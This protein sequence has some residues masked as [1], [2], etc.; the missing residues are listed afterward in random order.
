MLSRPTASFK[1]TERL[2]YC[3]GDAF[4]QKAHQQ[5]GGE[6][7]VMLTGQAPFK[8]ALEVRNVAMGEVWKEVVDVHGHEWKGE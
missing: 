1:S 8:L 6:A 4:V 3:L 2:S 5:G 7:V